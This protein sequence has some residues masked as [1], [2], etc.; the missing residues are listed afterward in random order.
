V[1]E[2][3]DFQ[4]FKDTKEIKSPEALEQELI[5]ALPS[6]DEMATVMTMSSDELFVE[7][8]ARVEYSESL[9]KDI[10]TSTLIQELT[11]RALHME[12]LCEVATQLNE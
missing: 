8:L 2:I 4:W 1:A 3:V 5:E 7:L 9:R 12:L 6:L 10:S 11:N